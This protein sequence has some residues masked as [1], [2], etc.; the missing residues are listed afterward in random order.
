M[1]GN[2]TFL[3]PIAGSDTGRVIPAEEFTK[4]W[5][6]NRCT[7]WLRLVG[8]IVCI[9]LCAIT[10]A[11][12]SPSQR[13]VASGRPRLRGFASWASTAAIVVIA[14]LGLFAGGT[15][16][17]GGIAV[18][19]LSLDESV[20][21]NEVVSTFSA[22]Q[23]AVGSVPNDGVLYVIDVD[24]D[25]T[26]GSDFTGAMGT[27]LVVKA[28]QNIGIR[29][30]EGNRWVMDAAASSSDK[31]RHISIESGASLVVK[32]LEFTR[33]YASILNPKTYTLFV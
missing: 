10:V 11:E 3:G 20:E 1:E 2:T 6:E 18:R 9:Y 26:W 16:A 4:E 30:A 12:Q 19:R 32:N 24:A 21:A 17:T 15:H 28:G 13:K 7:Y 22:L 23:S 8:F 31:R 25:M 27:A 14:A 29:G 5:R 33:G